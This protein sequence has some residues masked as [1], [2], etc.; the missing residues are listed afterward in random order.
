[1]VG[2]QPLVARVVHPGH[3]ARHP[4][5]GPC[6]EGDHQVDL[7]VAGGADHVVVG[8]H[9]GCVE[10]ADLARVTD[11]PLG[12]GHPGGALGGG[13]PVEDQ[14]VVTV[15]DELPGDGASHAARADDCDSH[16][17]SSVRRLDRVQ[18]VLELGK[19]PAGHDEVQL[20]ALLVDRV[21]SGDHRVPQPGDERDTAA[22]DLL[23]LDEAPTGPARIDVDLRY[24]ERPGRVE[25]VW[26]AAHSEQVVQR[27]VV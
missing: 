4:E 13:V 26:G 12:G 14:D 1:R 15:V 19:G 9:P 23:D 22:E 24:H 17:D 16:A 2:E 8:L 11:D 5:L 3:R 25:V 21:S 10:R 18:P 6:Q 7:V 20:V 27:W